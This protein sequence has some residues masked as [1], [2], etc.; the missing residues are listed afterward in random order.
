[1]KSQ[2]LTQSFKWKQKGSLIVEGM[3]KDNIGQQS[4]GLLVDSNILVMDP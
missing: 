3:R 4:C 2:G 1:M